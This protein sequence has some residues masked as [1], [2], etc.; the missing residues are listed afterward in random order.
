MYNKTM[1]PIKAKHIVESSRILH[2]AIGCSQSMQPVTQT[3]KHRV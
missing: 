3:A 1:N 2:E